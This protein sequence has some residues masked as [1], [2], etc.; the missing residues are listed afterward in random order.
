MTVPFPGKPA[1]R[2]CLQRGV[3]DE[4][5]MGKLRWQRPAC[6]TGFTSSLSIPQP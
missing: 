5:K 1:P 2:A 3:S 6:P 4:G